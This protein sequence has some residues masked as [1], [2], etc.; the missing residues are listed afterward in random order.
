MMKIGTLLTNLKCIISTF[1]GDMRKVTVYCSIDHFS[2][3]GYN[4]IY[5][6]TV[7]IKF[8]ASIVVIDTLFWVI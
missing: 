6:D 5:L 1:V 7:K 2:L 8:I 3:F 4:F